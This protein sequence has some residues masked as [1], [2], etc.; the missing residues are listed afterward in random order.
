MMLTRFCCGT[1]SMPTESDIRSCR[2][3]KHIQKIYMHVA[4][5]NG[6]GLQNNFFFY[7]EFIK[8]RKVHCTLYISYTI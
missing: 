3:N 6:H 7:L 4:F 5:Y 8:V 2:G 1:L